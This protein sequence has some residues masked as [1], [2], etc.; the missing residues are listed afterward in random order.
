MQ[1]CRA[2]RDGVGPCC[3]LPTILTTIGTG[4]RRTAGHTMTSHEFRI[5]PPH[6][7]RPG[8][9][10]S[11]ASLGRRHG[12]FEAAPGVRL[13]TDVRLASRV[14]VRV[15]GRRQSAPAPAADMPGQPRCAGLGTSQPGRAAG[16]GGHR[17]A[18][19][20]GRPGHRAE[21]NSSNCRRRGST[22]LCDPEG[23]VPGNPMSAVD[24]PRVRRRNGDHVNPASALR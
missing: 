8:P 12:Q 9:V 5:V 19:K 3:T 20:C 23:L 13:R 10:L 1:T 17:P 6:H 15:Q 7:G 2:L 11:P 4:L 24:K 21:H 14:Q 16:R 22:R 18:E